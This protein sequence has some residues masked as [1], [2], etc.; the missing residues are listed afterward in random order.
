[1]Q[2]INGNTTQKQR[3]DMKYEDRLQMMV[4]AII[5]GFG[6]NNPMTTPQ[7]AVDRAVE[8]LALIKSRA[9]AEG[10]TD[11]DAKITR[12]ESQRRKESTQI[13]KAV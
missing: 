1:M 13:V 8:Y 6:T 10:E 2:S 4:Q 9:R 5:V 12:Y 11:R 3:K 7:T